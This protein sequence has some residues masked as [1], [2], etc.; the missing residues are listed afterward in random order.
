M[1]PKLISSSANPLIKR[2]RALAKRKEREERGAF[3]VE[4]IRTVWQALDSGAGIEVILVAPELLTSEAARLKVEDAASNGVPVVRVTRPV[5]ESLASRENPSGLAAVVRV[6]KRTLHDINIDSDAIL[7]CLHEVGNPGNLGTII[8]TVDAIGGS[9]VIVIG[10]ATDP[11]HP[12]A[13]KASMGALF[14]IPM[15][16]VENL[17]KL[18]LWARKHGIAVVTTSSRARDL[19]WSIAYPSPVLLLFGSEGEGLADVQVEQGDLA[20][21]IPMYGTADSLNLA[22]AVGVLLYEV[23]RQQTSYQARETIRVGQFS[24]VQKSVGGESR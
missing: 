4:G 11:H 14:N 15:A 13:V 1:A 7:V 20:V 9:G 17:E 19:H 8:R 21:R 6:S 18:F 2:I 12:V 10:E 3:V 23:K 24:D 22:V 16:R 5:F